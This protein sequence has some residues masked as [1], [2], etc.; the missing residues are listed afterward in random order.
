VFL[1]VSGYPAAGILGQPY[2]V[3]RTEAQ[4]SRL[5]LA[6][7]FESLVLAMSEQVA[8][9]STEVSASA[10]GL[11]GAA[12]AAA[13]EVGTAQHTITSLTTS[14]AEIKEIVAMIDAIAAQTRLLALNAT[15]EAARV[16]AQVEQIREACEAVAAG[17]AT[18][19]R[20]SAR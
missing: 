20:P 12:S 19:G 4:T 10:S 16:T 5:R 6:D 14:S 11:T 13:T 9:A 7:E 1:H 2:N 8:T 15:I 18:V 3:I 17:M